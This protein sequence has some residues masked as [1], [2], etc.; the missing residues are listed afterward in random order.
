MKVNNVVSNTVY[1]N[2]YSTEKAKE[3]DTKEQGTKEVK[4]T[5]NKAETTPKSDT[6]KNIDV[7][8]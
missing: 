5:D 7:C 3:T 4:E 6:G 1:N 8:V 2:Q